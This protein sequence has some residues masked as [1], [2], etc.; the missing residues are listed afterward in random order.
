[1]ATEM[2][3]R[4]FDRSTIAS[5]RLAGAAGLLGCALGVAGS[6]IVD[7]FDA[8]ATTASAAE[9]VKSVEED[10]TALLVGMLLST[11]AVSLWL[12]FGAGV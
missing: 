1:M 4:S 10:R 9:I 12:V 8:P 3:T 6:L 7:I 11:A 5:L 2:A